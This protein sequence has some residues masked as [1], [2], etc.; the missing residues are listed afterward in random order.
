MPR[1]GAPQN[2]PQF[3]ADKRFTVAIGGTEG[4]TIVAINNKRKP[5]D[6][7]R[8][9][10]AIAAAIDRK[11]IVDGAMEG[12]GAPIGSH[13]VPSDAGYVDLTGASPHD[14]ERRSAC[15]RKPAWRRR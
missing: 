10:R 5:F 4:K 1:F 9:R 15:S 11:A 14:I 8:V 13:L 2:L 6:D 12:Y 3:Q 7:V